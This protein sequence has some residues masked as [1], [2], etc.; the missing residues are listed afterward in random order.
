MDRLLIENNM[1]NEMNNLKV[2]NAIKAST[3]D[4]DN[5]I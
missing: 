5:V 4:Y 3:H 2:K 1:C